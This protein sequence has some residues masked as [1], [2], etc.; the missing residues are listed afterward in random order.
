MLKL[1]IFV[2]FACASTLNILSPPSMT[3]YINTPAWNRF[4]GPQFLSP[5]NGTA[6]YFDGNYCE[7]VNKNYTGYILFISSVSGCLED[8]VYRNLDSTNP[9]AIITAEDVVVPGFT[10]HIAVGNSE[11]T[12]SGKHP[13]L[14]GS[15]DEL[16][17]LINYLRK[18]DYAEDVIIELDLPDKNYWL[19]ILES[20]EY[21]YVIRIIIPLF[22]LPTSLYAFHLLYIN[23][24]IKKTTITTTK[25]KNNNYF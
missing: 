11:E 4:F 7:P 12:M 5:T 13:F 22:Q 20:I 3:K 1:L 16:R 23:N 15:S 8:K 6:I 14:E 25:V 2:L 17:E 19:D 24:R 21:F 9:V 10:H 18:S